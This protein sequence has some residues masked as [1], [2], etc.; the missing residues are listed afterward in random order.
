[1][2]FQIS[3]LL[4]L[5]IIEPFRREASKRPKTADTTEYLNKL[6]TRQ[7]KLDR[8]RSIIKRAGTIDEKKEDDTAS[9]KRI[10]MNIFGIS[11]PN[12]VVTGKVKEQIE[13]NER[14]IEYERVK[15]EEAAQARLEKMKNRFHRPIKTAAE[16]SDSEEE[17]PQPTETIEIEEY[18]DEEIGRK[19]KRKGKKKPSKKKDV[20]TK[21]EKTIKPEQDLIPHEPVIILQPS[22]TKDEQVKQSKPQSDSSKKTLPDTT[23]NVNNNKVGVQTFNND[24]ALSQKSEVVQ[25]PLK[26][27]EQVLVTQT[28][29]I[30]QDLSRLETDTL[31]KDQ[32]K[33]DQ[34]LEAISSLSSKAEKLDEVPAKASVTDEL[35]RQMIE[36]YKLKLKEQQEAEKKKKDAEKLP[37]KEKAKAKNNLLDENAMRFNTNFRSRKGYQGNLED[38][39]ND[40]KREDDGHMERE[41]VGESEKV[42]WAFLSSMGVSK[43]ALIETGS[44]L[45]SELFA[46]VREILDYDTS[47]T[48]KNSFCINLGR[49]RHQP[50]NSYE[51]S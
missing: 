23:Q 39:K 2:L 29:E 4:N 12:S 49:R 36:K 14:R 9:S 40:S 27:K 21:K 10:L 6:K 42:S 31:I 44:L 48:T 1:M 26:V 5:C 16:E 3:H 35:R 7:S 43:Q 32:Q 30:S 22:I 18:S 13:A 28:L 37:K 11:L 38:Q 17:E 50:S 45:Q 25:E 34:S 20:K 51:G 41:I 8:Y 15:R 47:N 33:N 19:H 24:K 46:S